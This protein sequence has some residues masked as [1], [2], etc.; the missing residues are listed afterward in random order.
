LSSST[1]QI[2]QHD[3]TYCHDG[4]KKDARGDTRRR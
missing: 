2:F 4:V 3:Y 1:A